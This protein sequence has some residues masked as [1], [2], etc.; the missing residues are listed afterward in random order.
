MSLDK[1]K[2]YIG[3]CRKMGKVSFGAAAYSD[4]KSKKAKLILIDENAADN[5]KEKFKAVS[6]AVG[7]P[8]LELPKGMLE[9]AAGKPGART[10]VIKDNNLANKINLIGR[11]IWQK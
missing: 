10:A 9:D 6:V 8:L 4:I 1:V 5:T 2:T 7:I 11:E 3:F